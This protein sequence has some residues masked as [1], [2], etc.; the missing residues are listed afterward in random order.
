[1][2]MLDRMAEKAGENWKAQNARIETLSHQL[3]IA[4]EALGL[5]VQRAEDIRNG[6]V[7]ESQEELA[8]FAEVVS[9]QALKQMDQ[10]N[11]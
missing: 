4:R 1:M 10:D 9:R 2:S 11:G 5:I 6:E 7:C 8:G 3:A